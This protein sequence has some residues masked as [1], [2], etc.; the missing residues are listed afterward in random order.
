GL[1]DSRSSRV[2]DRLVKRFVLQRLESPSDRR[3]KQ[4]RL[5]EE[6]IRLQELVRKGM[7]SC[8]QRLTASIPPHRL[9]AV[10]TVLEDLLKNSSLSG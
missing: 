8:E 5:T 3:C 10:K 4:V 6:G 7:N 2:V 9:Q 1:S